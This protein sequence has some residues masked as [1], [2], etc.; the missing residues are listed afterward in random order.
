MELISENFIYNDNKLKNA[1]SDGYYHVKCHDIWDNKD[2]VFIF[3]NNNHKIYVLR[4][5]IY[6]N[7]ED[8]K[9]FDCYIIKV[10]KESSGYIIKALYNTTERKQIADSSNFYSM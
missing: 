7:I 5:N 1:L 6:N 3:K 4:K 2:I 9:R 8:F 10:V